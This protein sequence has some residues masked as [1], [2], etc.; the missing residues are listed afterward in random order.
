MH[1]SIQCTL[2]DI[3]HYSTILLLGGRYVPTVRHRVYNAIN[4]VRFLPITQRRDA[5]R[6]LLNSARHVTKRSCHILRYVGLLELRNE[7]E[8][9]SEYRIGNRNGRRR[10]GGNIYSGADIYRISIRKY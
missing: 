2:M 1:A 9:R 7:M 5:A 4:R 10:R 3:K 8:P 6:N